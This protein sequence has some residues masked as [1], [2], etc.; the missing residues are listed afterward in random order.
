M[1]QTKQNP[2]TEARIE[3]MNAL[4]RRALSGLQ[5]KQEELEE[6]FQALRKAMRIQV[7]IHGKGSTITPTWLELNRIVRKRLTFILTPKENE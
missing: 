3:S 2:L 5:D 6:T 1:L 7:A 4:L